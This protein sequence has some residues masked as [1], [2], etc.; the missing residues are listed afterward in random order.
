MQVN[1]GTLLY[2]MAPSGL[3]LVRFTFEL[4]GQDVSSP[5]RLFYSFRPG[6][7][8]PSGHRPMEHTDNPTPQGCRLWSDEYRPTVC[9]TLSLGE[10][11]Y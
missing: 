8:F 4:S 7:F 10:P 5:A 3:K 1:A 11:G 6:L 2:I 9:M